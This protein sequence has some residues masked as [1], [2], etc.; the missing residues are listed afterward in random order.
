M[1]DGEDRSGNRAKKTVSRPIRHTDPATGPKKLSK[2]FSVSLFLREPGAFSLGRPTRDQARAT[3]R[4][5][6]G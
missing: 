4:Q 6:L 2:N 3:S 5:I 1:A